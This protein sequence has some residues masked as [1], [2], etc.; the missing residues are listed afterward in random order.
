MSKVYEKD[1]DPLIKSLKEED[2]E[3]L[4]DYLHRFMQYIGDSESQTISSGS[5]LRLYERIVK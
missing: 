1:F 4:V 3:L 2:V 5:M